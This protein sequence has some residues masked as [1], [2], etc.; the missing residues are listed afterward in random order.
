MLSRSEAKSPDGKR[1]RKY[2]DKSKEEG[3]GVLHEVLQEREVEDVDILWCL[4][5]AI[6]ERDAEAIQ[7]CGY[8]LGI[9]LPYD[10]HNHLLDILGYPTA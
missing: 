4:P 5:R 3:G 8:L 7:I 2:W 9:M 1:I 10:R 6:E